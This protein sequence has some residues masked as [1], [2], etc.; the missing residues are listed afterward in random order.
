MIEVSGLLLMAGARPV[1]EAKSA[2]GFEAQSGSLM[3]PMAV[4]SPHAKC[5]VR[6]G[7]ESETVGGF[8]MMFVLSAVWKDDNGEVK[9]SHVIGVF[10]TRSKAIDGAR[11]YVKKM[12]VDEFHVDEMPVDKIEGEPREYDWDADEVYDSITY[13]ERF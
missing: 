6:G 9:S 11:E 2:K 1:N 8:S 10:N 7:F 12:N 13:R 3:Q 5:R 4:T